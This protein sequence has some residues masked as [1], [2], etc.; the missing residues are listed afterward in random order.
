MPWGPHVLLWFY[1]VAS[2]LVKNLVRTHHV[3]ISA[4]NVH[5]LRLEK[6]GVL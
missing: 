3:V 4:E 2:Q 1:F 5:V 6:P